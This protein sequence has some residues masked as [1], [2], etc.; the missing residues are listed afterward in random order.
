M[1]I[2]TPEMQSFIDEWA[3]LGGP[4]ARENDLPVSAMLACASI[5]SGWGKGPIY[6]ATLNPFS[7]QKWPHV[8]YPK[9]HQ[10]FWRETIVQT[11]PV[12]KAR[13]PFNCATS[14][15]DAV[16]QWCEWIL[17]WGE[18]DGPPGNQ[19]PKIPQVARASAIASRELLLKHR[20]NGLEFARNLPL[21]GF[22]ETATAALRQ[23]SGEGYANRL[24]DFGM[25]GYH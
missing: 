15:A 6:L 10:T 5:E 11:N 8:V 24:R 2:I 9:T 14:H 12:R 16:R 1:A 23:K 3:D 13:A 19:D 20:Q 21:V 18:A 7:L 4:V 17:H 25:E 22:G